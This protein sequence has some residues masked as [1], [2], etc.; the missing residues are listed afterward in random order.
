M[1]RWLYASRVV[2]GRP[3]D[4]ERVLQSDLDELL[5]DTA[6]R[7][8]D[9]SI[10][11]AVGARIVGRQLTKSVRLQVGVAYRR[12]GS[13]HIPVRW[14]ADPL[15]RAFPSFEG[16]I[17]VEAM[18]AM[19]AQL[20]LVG[21]YRPP[22]GPLGAAA[23]ALGMNEV[24]T[25]TGNALLDRVV[26][27]LE[28][29]LQTSSSAL[30]PE[31]ARNRDASRGVMRVREVMTPDPIVLDPDMPLRT[32]AKLL[33][34][35]GIS[36]APV[37]SGDGELLGVLS[38]SDLLDKEATEPG[39]GLDRAERRRRS[40]I[41]AG[42][43]CTR[44]ART[45]HPDVVLHDAA[46]VMIDD[47]VSRLVV[48]DNAKIV[49]IIT[50]HDILNALTRSDAEL[51]VAIADVLTARDLDALDVTIEWGVAIVR[52]RVPTRS[53]ADYAVATISEIDGVV[54]S[55]TDALTWE[56]DDVELPVALL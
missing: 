17:E 40:A 11:T 52:G 43:A 4:L 14:T 54:G 2:R 27:A 3:S 28:L 33:L 13:L 37:V 21:K 53:M 32:A 6:E 7:H 23:D 15:P 50:R 38:E 12:L 10:T 18:S 29:R 44:P 39:R 41:T 55:D 48:V 5:V 22:L 24:A 16:Y 42:Q 19:S 31:S 51:H 49:G 25:N 1:D 8:S 45:T 56:H 47:D 35:F 26:T 20:T 34:H 30:A 9:G 46:R 36:G